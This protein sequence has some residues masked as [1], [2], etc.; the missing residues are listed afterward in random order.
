MQQIALTLEPE[1]LRHPGLSPEDRESVSNA[2]RCL[3]ARYLVTQD[4]MTSPD[5]V[6]DYFR[7]RM[8]D[9]P[10]EVFSV[11]FLDTRHRVLRYQELFRGTISSA[12]VHPREVARIAIEVNA[13]AILVGHNHPSGDPEPGHADMQLTENLKNALAL[14]DV[15]L[16]DH[17]VVGC[18]D[19]VSFAE[20]GIL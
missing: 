4:V 8:M 5:L 17:I 14:I 12:A 11:L 2:I 19:A 20:R 16:L 15:R 13:A 10:Y 18:E 7:L 9:I 1:H 6:K 3:E